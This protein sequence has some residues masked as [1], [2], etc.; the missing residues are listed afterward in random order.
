MVVVGGEVSTI[1]IP[2]L[3]ATGVDCT[4]GIC[5]CCCCCGCP[6]T[7]LAVGKMEGAAADGDIPLAT[8]AVAVGSNTAPCFFSALCFRYSDLLNR[9]QVISVRNQSAS[10]H[11]FVKIIPNFLLIT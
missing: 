7:G 5:C 1:L 2:G 6:T 9:R 10:A 8:V 3:D 4:V 11:H